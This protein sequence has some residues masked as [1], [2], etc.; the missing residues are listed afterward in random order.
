MLDKKI[1]YVSGEESA[2]QIKLRALRIAQKNPNLYL[3]S[4]TQT[5]EIFKQVKNLEPDLIIIDSIQ[6]VY[7]DLVQSASGSIAQIRECAAEFQRL[8]KSTN[9]PIILIGHINKEGEI[10]GPKILEHIVDVVLQFEGDRNYTHRILRAI[11]NRFGAQHELAIY[12]MTEAGL[13]PVTNPSSLFL[14]DGQDIYSG[15]SVAASMEGARPFLIEIQ[16]LVSPTVYSVPQRTATGL[17][18]RRL[19]MLLAV[20]DKRLGLQIA[21]KDVF[22][23]IAGGLKI[24][25]PALDLSVIASIVSSQFDHLIAPKFCFAAEV[26]LSGE[27]RAVHKIAQRIQEADKQGFEKI[28]VS[29][30]NAIKELKTQQIQ[31][32]EVAKVSDMMKLLFK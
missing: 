29:R 5:Q 9:I 8:A 26:G 22:L 17:D 30:Q 21:N 4:E 20:L 24:N 16:A 10:A 1:L 6:T 12:E 3:Y 13:H 19:N 15:T 14:S 18:P 23:N 28:F 11:K 31:I 32:I 27:I 25:D 2:E 7:S